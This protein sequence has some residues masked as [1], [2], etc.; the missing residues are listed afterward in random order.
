MRIILGAPHSTPAQLARTGA[1]DDEDGGYDLGHEE[2]DLEPPRVGVHFSL[3][4]GYLGEVPEGKEEAAMVVDELVLEFNYSHHTHT[5]TLG[6][7]SNSFSPP[8]PCP[9]ISS[10]SLSISPSLYFHARV[11][12]ECQKVVDEEL[13]Q[14]D[15]P[16]RKP[17]PVAIEDHV[18][19]CKDAEK[20][21][22]AFHDTPAVIACV[23]DL[24]GIG[25]VLVV[26]AATPVFVLIEWPVRMK[27]GVKLD[28][29]WRTDGARG[30]RFARPRGSVARLSSCA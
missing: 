28:K 10:L 1:S 21:E 2:A 27:G 26:R 19:R 8:V 20:D 9:H 12:H 23:G 7:D 13:E 22:A 3:V 24:E 4:L 16:N 11:Q 14:D 17:H 18:T 6:G 25:R 30:C 15:P 29:S 5:L